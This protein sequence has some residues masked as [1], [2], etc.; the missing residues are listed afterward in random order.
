M[1]WTLVTCMHN[2]QPLLPQGRAQQLWRTLEAMCVPK[3]WIFPV[4]L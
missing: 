3:S 1:L 4:P 2:T